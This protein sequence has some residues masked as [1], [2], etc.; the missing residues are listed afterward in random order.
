MP[1]YTFEIK[2]NGGARNSWTYLP[3]DD[4]ARQFTRILARSFNGSDQY[5]GPAHMT[6]KDP[7]G[8]LIASIQF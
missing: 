2:W 5:R 4:S 7:G 8:A 3:T 6:V 1:A